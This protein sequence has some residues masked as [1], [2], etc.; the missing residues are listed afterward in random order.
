MKKSTEPFVMLPRSLVASDA[1][2]SAS[3]NA[4]RFID[5]LLLEHM[6]HGGKE[7]GRLKAPYRQ[8]EQFG[9]GRRHVTPAIS[10]A[11]ALG[12][13]TCR[14]GGMRVPTEYAVTWLPLHDNTPPTDQWREFQAP[15]PT[16]KANGSHFHPG[17]D[18]PSVTIQTLPVT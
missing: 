13:A 3:I 9:I 15:Q 5:F 17:A 14:R 7:N 2:R 12:L 11:E 10:E 6:A 16:A 1:W 18:R 8:L 4:R